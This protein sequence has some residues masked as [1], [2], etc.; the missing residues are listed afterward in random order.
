[1]TLARAVNLLIT[2]YERAQQK[3]HVKDPMAYAL[4]KV[5]QKADA[6]SKKL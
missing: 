4:H 5:W 3:P 1:M 6:E 2:E